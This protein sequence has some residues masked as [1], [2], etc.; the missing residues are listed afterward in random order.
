MGSILACFQKTLIFPIDF[1]YFIN[2]RCQ[3]GTTL[4]SFCSTLAVILVY[5]GFTLSSLWR[6]LAEVSAKLGLSWPNL[7]PNSDPVEPKS[8]N[9]EKVLVFKSFLKDSMVQNTP[10]AASADPG[11]GVRALAIRGFEPRIF[12]TEGTRPTRAC[13][14]KGRGPIYGLPPLP[15]TSSTRRSSIGDR[16]TAIGDRLSLLVVR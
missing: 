6:K 3:L 9:V 14:H 11:L 15:P 10:H 12:G 1:N 13:G 7:A 5:F 4:G 8:G 16:R 2:C